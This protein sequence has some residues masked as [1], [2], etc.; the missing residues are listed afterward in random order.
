M[1]GESD[2]PLMIIRI[3]RIWSLNT[4]NFTDSKTYYLRGAL[5]LRPTDF[6]HEPTHLFYKNEV[7]KEISREVTICL[8]QV[9]ANSETNR[10]KCSVM[11][12]KQYVSSRITEIDERDVY[13]CEA[14]YSLQLKTF[15]KFTKGLKSK[16]SIE[17]ELCNF[18]VKKNWKT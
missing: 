6:Q 16:W 14:K 18:F 8:S 11:N 15:R 2:K 12:S 7:Y 13:V 17:L 1:A 3:D 4:D 10:K 5:F 9:T